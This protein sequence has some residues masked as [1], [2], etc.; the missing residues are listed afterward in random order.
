MIF[1]SWLTL[2]SEEIP[3]NL[4]ISQKFY[5]YLDNGIKILDVGCGFGRY[6]SLALNKNFLYYGI[7]LNKSAIKEAEFK[8]KDPKI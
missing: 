7:D 4:P 8:Y 5:N 6:A 1:N 3:A 2:Q